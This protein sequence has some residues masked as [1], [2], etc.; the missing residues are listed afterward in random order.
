MPA[1]MN[2][3]EYWPNITPIVLHLWSLHTFLDAP[4]RNC[5]LILSFY[6]RFTSD[7]WIKYLS[8]TIPIGTYAIRGV[9]S[10]I[11]LQVLFDC[12][13]IW[14]EHSKADKW[15]ERLYRWK[16][17]NKDCEISTGDRTVA[18]ATTTLIGSDKERAD[19]LNLRDKARQAL[20]WNDKKKCRP[21]SI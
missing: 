14:L 20:V 16:Y 3:D 7:F 13:E 15:R 17:C 5:S 19:Q 8:M 6:S 1:R 2:E 9:M 11:R 4:A 18:A 10:K 21:S 12:K